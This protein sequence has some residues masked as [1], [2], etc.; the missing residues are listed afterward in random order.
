MMP[1]QPRLVDCRAGK[2][3]F[4]GKRN[5]THSVLKRSFPS[6]SPQLTGLYL[7][8]K[9]RLRLGNAALF[10]PQPCLALIYRLKRDAT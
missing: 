6:V 2:S 10:K 7:R 4:I 5:P 1:E 8:V 9:T 3:I